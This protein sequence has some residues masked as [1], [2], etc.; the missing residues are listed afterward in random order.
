MKMKQESVVLILFFYLQLL[1]I[2]SFNY[3]DCHRLFPSRGGTW[4]DYPPYWVPNC[5]QNQIKI[6]DPVE[7]RKCL[8]GRTIYAMGNS[9]GRQAL[10]GFVEMLG[11]ASVTRED[12]RD[13]CPKHETFWGD[14][15]H[16]DLFDV[17]LKYLFMQFMDGYN[18]SG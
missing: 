3:D 18:Y 4:T 15:C 13:I 8:K 7:T 9:V 11:A 12:Q 14:S 1:G 17:K 5:K 10:F 6:F 16:S 2:Y